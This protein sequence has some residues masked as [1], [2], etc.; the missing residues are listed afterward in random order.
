MKL[1]KGKYLNTDEWLLNCVYSYTDE[2][3]RKDKPQS[4][5]RSKCFFV[6]FFW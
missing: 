5:S 3:A 6:L 4:G 1:G 2:A